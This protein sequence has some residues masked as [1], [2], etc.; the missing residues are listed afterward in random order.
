[1]GKVRVG[2]DPVMIIG[3]FGKSREGVSGL[4]K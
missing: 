3:A 4:D 2:L 1:M